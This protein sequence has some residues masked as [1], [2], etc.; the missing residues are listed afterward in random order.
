MVLTLPEAPQNFHRWFHCKFQL[1]KYK[2]WKDSPN[3]LISD[4]G[5]TRESIES[6]QFDMYILAY[7]QY[8]KSNEAQIHIP[9]FETEMKNALYAH[10]KWDTE[11]KE[12]FEPFPVDD[13][14]EQREWMQISNYHQIYAEEH[15]EQI[16]RSDWEYRY[17][18]GLK[19]IFRTWMDGS[20]ICPQSLHPQ[21]KLLPVF[22]QQ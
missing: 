17:C 16:T 8:L 19:K 18:L 13:L 6:K 11:Q 14:N 20:N 2:P 3:T 9:N 7:E 1:I 5:F 10:G 12:A 22:K 4:F 21:R 15:K